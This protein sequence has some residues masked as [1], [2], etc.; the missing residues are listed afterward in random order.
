MT[1]FNAIG[2]T[3]KT[4]WNAAKKGAKK[5]GETIKTGTIKTG[6]FIHKTIK[7]VPHALLDANKWLW[8]GVSDAGKGF[9]DTIGGV[10]HG[11]SKGLTSGIGEGVGSNPIMLP[12]IIGLGGIVA[13]SAMKA[14]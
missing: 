7:G 10:I 12:L 6:K 13:F 1:F 8:S 14:I 11:S 3:I 4:G 9:G 5:I 2:N